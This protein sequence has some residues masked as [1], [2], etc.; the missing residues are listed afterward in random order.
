MDELQAVVDAEGG[1]MRV[2]ELRARGFARRAIEGAVATATISRPRNGWVATHDADPVENVLSL[3]AR[4][5][6]HEEAL[7]VWESALHQGFVERDSLARMP[8]P[9]AA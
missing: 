6:P 7:A 4:C 3:V 2:A 9:T 8:L 1:V 5:L